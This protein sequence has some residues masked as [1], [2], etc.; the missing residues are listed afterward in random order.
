MLKHL[1][2]CVIKQQ[3][4]LIDSSCDRFMC[5]YCD[6]DFDSLI[7]LDDHNWIQHVDE[8]NY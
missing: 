3:E 2:G 1:D 5:V 6:G 8:Y 4:L 7:E